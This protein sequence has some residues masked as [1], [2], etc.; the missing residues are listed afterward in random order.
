MEKGAFYDC[1]RSTKESN[2]QIAKSH[3]KRVPL[4]LKLEDYDNLKSVAEQAGQ[5]VNGYIK[6]AIAEKMEREAGE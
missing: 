5:T 6:Q 3:L 2:D 4:D 1:K